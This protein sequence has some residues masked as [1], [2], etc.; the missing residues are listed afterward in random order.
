MA[1]RDDQ[2]L[3]F[4]EGK[5]PQ[6]AG[7]HTRHRDTPPCHA[8]AGVDVVHC[9]LD[10]DRIH[11]GLWRQCDYSHNFTLWCFFTVGVFETTQRYPVQFWLRRANGGDQV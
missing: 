1:N 11:P 7:L 10:V 3:L 5:P 4:N 9:S 8:N 2:A 6:P